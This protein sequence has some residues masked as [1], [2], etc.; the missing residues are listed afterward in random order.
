MATA[1]RFQIVTE[2][3]AFEGWRNCLAV[4]RRESPSRPVVLSFV[5][6]RVADAPERLARLAEDV[7]RAARLYHPSI[8]RVIGMGTFG[9]APVVLQ[10]WRDGESLRELLD[11]GTRMPPEVAARIV[12][13]A[14]EAVHHSH[15]RAAEE[16]RPFAHGALRAERVLVAADGSVVVSGFGRAAEGDGAVPSPAE[17]VRSLGTLLLQ[18]L[19]GE[20]PTNEGLPGVPDKLAEVA[21]RAADRAREFASAEAFRAAVAAA[22]P[23][24]GRDRVRS[25][26]DGVLPPE[27]GTRG[28]RHRSLAAALSEAPGPAAPKSPP[29]KAPAKAAVAEEVAED[30]IVAALTPLP[31]AVAA[32]VKRPPA[33]PPAARAAVPEPA[34]TADDLIV[35]EATG[36]MIAHRKEATPEI[37]FPRPAPIP[38][39]AWNVVGASAGVALVIGVALGYVLGR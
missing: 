38:T 37:A 6:A 7:E 34:Q 11:T 26:A 20:Q 36:P 32:A 30:A 33:P 15:G 9:D 3:A 12:A 28:R 17:D 19:A 24:A 2:F 27:A 29:P 35:G 1:P 22:V 16:A 10:E 13:D 39:V 4:D 21:A 8:L 5:P 31:G 18:C 25:W 23:L 14:A